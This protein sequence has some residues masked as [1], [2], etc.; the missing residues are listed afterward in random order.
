MEEHVSERW[1]PSAAGTVIDKRISSLGFT[2]QTKR[3]PS[4]TKRDSANRTEG[5]GSIHLSYPIFPSLCDD[6]L[7]AVILERSRCAPGSREGEMTGECPG[8]EWPIK[9]RCVMVRWI[10]NLVSSSNG[11]V[12][13]RADQVGSFAGKDRRA[14]LRLGEPVHALPAV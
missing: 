6:G 9:F 10:G 1:D 11:R 4:R 3:I 12:S 7:L 8:H 14:A 2:A 5:T 13:E